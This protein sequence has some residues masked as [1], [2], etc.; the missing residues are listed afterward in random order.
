MGW[1]MALDLTAMSA[2]F[3]RI[4]SDIPQSFTIGSSTYSGGRTNLNIEKRL[5]AFGGDP[6]YR[7]SLLANLNVIGTVP[8]TGSIV[9]VDSVQYRV[10]ATETDSARIG[11][12]IDLGDKYASN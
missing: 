4:I 12:R 9:T 10:L 3:T 2:V 1:I 11:V 7:F 5:T 8:T 6:N